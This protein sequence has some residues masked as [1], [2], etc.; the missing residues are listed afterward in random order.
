MPLATPSRH[1]R[2][3]RPS[4]A[5]SGPS[6]NSASSTAAS[7]HVR[8]LEHAAGLGE[9]GEREP[10]PR[11]DRLVV[12]APAAVA[13]RAARAGV[14]ASPRRARR[15]GRSGRARRARAARRARPRPGAHVNVS[16][17]TPSVSASCAEANPPPSSAELAQQVLDGLLDHVAVALVAGDGPAVEV[18][19]NEQRVVVEHL[20]E[21][22]HE[23]ALV[24]RVA[25]EA[26]ADEVVHA[27]E[28][29]PVERRRHERRARRGAGGTRAR[30]PAGTSAR[31]RTRP[32]PGRTARAAR[33]RRP[34]GPAR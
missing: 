5:E 34:P 24:D 9:R 27:A 14:R 2:C 7:T 3:R 20:L 1:V 10:V 33:E 22:R 17:S 15:G 8:P 26:A 28:R 31:A 16:P 18:R 29:H 23:P 30:R 19:R 4:P 12:A 6:T 11:R 25:V 21:V 13:A 32:T